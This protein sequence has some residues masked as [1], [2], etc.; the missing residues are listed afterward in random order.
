M[1]E[2]IVNALGILVEAIYNDCYGAYGAGDE[3]YQGE[4][5]DEIMAC[6]EA[7]VNAIDKKD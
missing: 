1:K 7:I 4:Y 3:Y 2:E 6:A 5:D